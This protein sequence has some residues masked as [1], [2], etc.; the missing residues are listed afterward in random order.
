MRAEQ[1]ANKL[2]MRYDGR[3]RDRDPSEAPEG[4]PFAVRLKTPTDGEASIDDAV[5]GR[6]TVRNEEIDDYI[7][8]RADGTP[9]YMLAVVV[10]DHDMGVTHVVRGSDHVTN[11]ATQIQIVRALGGEAPTYAHH[12]LLTG[13]Q[14]EALS[15]RLGTLALRDL[16]AQGVKPYALLSLMARLGSSD[17]VELH[18]DMAAL[19]EGFDISRFGSAPTK[20]DAQDLFPLTAR[21]L[22]GLP[23]D[24]VAADVDIFS[25]CAL[26]G[27]INENTIVVAQLI[28]FE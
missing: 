5:Q 10:D 8:L 21:Y 2:P 3:W 22:G 28:S 18:S 17:P 12:S 11:T 16:R 6:V 24:A 4:A 14:G 15:K 19:I 25:P 1:R 20:F 7:I 13:P 23:L 27:A 26:G 9:T